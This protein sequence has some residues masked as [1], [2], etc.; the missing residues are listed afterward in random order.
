MVPSTR[1]DG[2]GGKPKQAGPGGAPEP[3]A[4]HGLTLT[5]LRRYPNHLDSLSPIRHPVTCIQTRAGALTNLLPR[6]GGLPK[7]DVAEKWQM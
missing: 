5:V 7:G 1:P 4:T 6:Q 3:S 2:S